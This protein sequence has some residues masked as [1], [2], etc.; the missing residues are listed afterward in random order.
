MTDALRNQYLR[1]LGVVQYV[2]KDLPVVAAVP[3][4]ESPVAGA[5]LPIGQTSPQGLRGSGSGAESAGAQK[6]SM[7]ELV[8]MV[9]TPKEAP[10]VS[11]P[12]AK[13]LAPVSEETQTQE[14]IELTL[15][16]WRA[17]DELL[18]CTSIEDT[19]PDPEQ[20]L[21]LGNILEAMGQGNGPLPQIEVIQWPLNP[22]IAGGEAELRDY[23]STL[24]GARLQTQPAKYLLLLGDDTAHWLL[25][26]SQRAT[27]ANGQ[28]DCFGQ[29]TAM[30]V[31]SLQA[32]I[33]QP[34][35]KRETWQTIR[36]LS[37]LRHVHRA[38][39]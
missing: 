16:L 29:V 37:P 10:P 25:S 4:Y 11:M 36:F 3:E 15:G 21:L 14:N 2:S 22:S 31:P 19:L 35:R 33:D 24:F 6:Q 8:E 5:D 18:V 38:E 12:D 34:E 13:S 23:L 27:L 9:G 30:L 1:S 28:V 7:A 20:I 39:S 32:M 17:T 26:D